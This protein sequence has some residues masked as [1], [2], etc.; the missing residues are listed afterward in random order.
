MTKDFIILNLLF[1]WEII[2]LSK[3]GNKLTIRLREFK[4]HPSRFIRITFTRCSV[5]AFLDFNSAQ[6]DDFS[7]FEFKGC[8]FYK[9]EIDKEN[10]VSIHLLRGNELVGAIKIQPLEISFDFTTK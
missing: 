5:A 10:I 2:H 1:G 4:D 3:K 6:T 8:I 9:A 7:L